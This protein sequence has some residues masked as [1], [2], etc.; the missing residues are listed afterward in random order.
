MKEFLID[1]IEEILFFMALLFIVI[2]AFTINLSVGLFIIGL[3]LIVAENKVV[4]I[5][6]SLAERK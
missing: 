1:Y 4:K 5:K 6:K 2:G 3:M